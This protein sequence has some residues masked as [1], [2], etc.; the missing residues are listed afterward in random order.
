MRRIR[1]FLRRGCL[2]LPLLCRLS[3]SCQRSWI[4]PVRPLSRLHSRL[5]PSLQLFGPPFRPSWRLSSLCR[6]SPYPS[7]LFLAL[8]GLFNN[9]LYG[10]LSG[11]LRRPSSPASSWVEL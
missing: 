9:P 6:H 10:L 3:F 4:T 8:G 5:S 2:Q 11:L 7:Q 1:L